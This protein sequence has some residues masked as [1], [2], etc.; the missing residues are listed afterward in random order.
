MYRGEVHRSLDRVELREKLRVDYD[1]TD[2]QYRSRHSVSGEI[3]GAITPDKE[4]VRSRE[5]PPNGLFEKIVS[6]TTGTGDH[7]AEG[8]PGTHLMVGITRVPPTTQRD[9]KFQE[10]FSQQDFTVDGV[11]KNGT[12][13]L[14]SDW[15]AERARR[16]LSDDEQ[17]TVSHSYDVDGMSG[18][19]LPVVVRADL[20]RDAREYLESEPSTIGER[21]AQQRTQHH[22]PKEF[23]GQAALSVAIEYRQ[24]SPELNV[25]AGDGTLHIENLRAEMQST[26]PNLSFRPR[27][28]STYNPEQQQVEW[29]KRSAQPGEILR[30]DIFGRMEELLDLGNIS[31]S[32]RGTILGDT[33]TG[34][35]I[36]GLYDRTGRDVTGTDGPGSHIETGHGVTVTGNITIDPTALRQE[37]RK[38]MDSTVSLNDTPFDAFDRLRTVCDREGMTITQSS[39]PTNPEPVA[40]QEG[41]FAIT[42]GEKGDGDDQPGELE[43]KRE[44]GDRGVVYAHM[45]VYGRYTPMSQDREVSQYSGRSDRT[46]DRIVRADEGGLETRGKSTVDI[47]A[48]SA[49]AELNSQL[50]QT[51]QA[52]LGG[53]GR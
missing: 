19:Q 3:R 13:L 51:I 39:E 32:V 35:T 34:T 8:F 4:V 23:E 26:F 49:D 31:V 48:R 44:Y 25:A 6:A 2:E 15:D 5:H 47:R 40:G 17:K 41:V 45:L 9:D 16:S 30:Y 37:A 46:E 12:V 18:E 14:E 43:V 36:E 33:L 52:G 27:D 7:V 11:P 1:I 29:R 50:V 38:V 10:G 42:K 22:D 24:D 21:D 20:H 28:N 53:D